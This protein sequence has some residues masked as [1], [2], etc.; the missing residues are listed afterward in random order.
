MRRTVI[1]AVWVVGATIPLLGAAVFVL[2]CCILPFHGVLHRMMPLCHLASD[3]MRGEHGDHDEDHH[4]PATPARP[5]QEPVK[6]IATD[7][8]QGVRLEVASTI[9]VTRSATPTD[10][11][12]YRSF[13]TLGAL[14]CDQ[15]VGL[16]RIL[17]QTFRI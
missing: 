15:D 6:R 17:I 3:V 13:I 16:Q 7:L 11:I 9:T 8:P 14:R 12:G 2:G 5:K 4:P 1:A 10:A